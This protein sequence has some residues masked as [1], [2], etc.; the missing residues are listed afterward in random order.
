L[1]IYQLPRQFCLNKRGPAGIRATFCLG[2]QPQ[3]TISFVRELRNEDDFVTG[4]TAFGVPHGPLLQ[5]REHLQK[6]KTDK[7][8]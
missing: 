8:Q 1:T 4:D 7:I 2:L 3:Y 6:F 5:A